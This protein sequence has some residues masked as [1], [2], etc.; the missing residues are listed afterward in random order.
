VCPF[1]PQ[2]K[3]AQQNA[4]LRYDTQARSPFWVVKP[5][6]E[7]AHAGL[8]PRLPEL[9]LCCYLVVHIENLLRQL[10]QFYFHLWPIYWLHFVLIFDIIPSHY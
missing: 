10:Q 1:F 8:L 6:S 4:A 7:H 5:A 9:G 2:K 3:S